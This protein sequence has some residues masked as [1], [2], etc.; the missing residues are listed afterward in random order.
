VW[1][2]LLLYYARVLDAGAKV[3]AVEWLDIGGEP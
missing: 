1:S 2:C 3:T